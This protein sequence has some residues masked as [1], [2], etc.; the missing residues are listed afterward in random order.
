MFERRG[1]IPGL[2]AAD[3]RRRH[4]TGDERV[5]G[6]IFEVPAAHRV[7]VDIRAGGQQDRETVLP[8]GEI[9][10]LVQRLKG[11]GLFCAGFARFFHQAGIPCARL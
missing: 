5:F 11:L 1:D 10:I 2:D 4:L 6:I 8:H 9:L 7:A 3:L